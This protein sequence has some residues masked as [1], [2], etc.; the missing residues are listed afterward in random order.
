MKENERF[1]AI[2]HNCRTTGVASQANGD[3]KFK[4]YLR[5]FASYVNMVH[6]EEGT[7]LLRGVEELLGPDPGG[8][9]ATP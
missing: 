7:E 1:R 9:G 8:Q 6:P 3:A 2:L 5:G 4:E